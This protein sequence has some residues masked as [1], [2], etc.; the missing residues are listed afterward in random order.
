MPFS[1]HSEVLWTFSRQGKCPHRIG[2]LV[3]N[4]GMEGRV[5]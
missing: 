3:L 5:I 4:G 1:F 2:H